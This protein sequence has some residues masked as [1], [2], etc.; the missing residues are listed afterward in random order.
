[1]NRQ[2]SH[3]LLAFGLVALVGAPGRAAAQAT[4][5][6]QLPANYGWT[7]TPSLLA[8]TMFDDN[9]LVRSN[10]GET[11]ADLVSVINPRIGAEFKGRR[12]EF[13]G[14]YDGA[15]RVFRAL[16][17]LNSYDHQASAGGPRLAT[18]HVTMFGGYQMFSA[19]TTELLQFVGVPYVRT[20]STSNL[21]SGGADAALS[22][23]LTLSG[24]YSFQM[25]D[26][27]QTVPF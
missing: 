13:A 2:R 17:T 9:A 7:V 22:K 3:L 10:G 26:F 18:R 6:G 27:E 1:M 24:S 20:G 11:P 25:V 14:T 21:L 16:G 4:N 12:G 19:P 23:R 5:T 8:D 15:F